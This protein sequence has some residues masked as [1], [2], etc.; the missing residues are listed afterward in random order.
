MSR[1]VDKIKREIVRTG[2]LS[3]KINDL[4]ILTDQDARRVSDKIN[5]LQELL[6]AYL[7]IEENGMV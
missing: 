7:Y 2:K 3:S 5:E 6:Y 4:G 1:K